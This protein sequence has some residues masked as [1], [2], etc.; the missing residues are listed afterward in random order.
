MACNLLKSMALYYS[1]EAEQGAAPAFFADDGSAYAKGRGAIR[2]A[3]GETSLRRTMLEVR[4]SSP[5]TV[6]RELQR[7]NQ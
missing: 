6:A 2:H 1:P 3:L 4:I 7:I 5:I